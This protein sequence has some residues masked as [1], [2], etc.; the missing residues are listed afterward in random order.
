[1]GVVSSHRGKSVRPTRRLPGTDDAGVRYQGHL[2]FEGRGHLVD[3][4]QGGRSSGPPP[5]PAEQDYAATA[6]VPPHTIQTGL[7]SFV[8]RVEERT[9]WRSRAFAA[10][11]LVADSGD[12]EVGTRHRDRRDGRSATRCP[13]RLRSCRPSTIRASQPGPHIAYRVHRGDARRQIET[14]GGVL[15]T[16]EGENAA[17]T[18]DLVEIGSRRESTL[19]Q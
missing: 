18:M 2:P 12:Q 16:Y 17:L 19:G 3:T 9:A 5:T 8:L 6:F 15:R 13:S 4:E 10:W 7:A 1:M 14:A 11:L